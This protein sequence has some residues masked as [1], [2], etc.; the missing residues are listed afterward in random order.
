MPHLNGQVVSKGSQLQGQQIASAL[1][2]HLQAS[3][4]IAG[5]QPT[6][7]AAVAE[8]SLTVDQRVVDEVGDAGA[9]GPAVERVAG[10]LHHVQGE[11][12][13]VRCAGFGVR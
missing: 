4:V 10:G 8:P 2:R 7:I 6:N 9:G 13:D 1:H 3:V 12:E 11:R 5:A